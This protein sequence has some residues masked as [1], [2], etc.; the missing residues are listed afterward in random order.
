MVEVYW[1]ELSGR[2]T[3]VVQGGTV[4]EQHQSSH[5]FSLQLCPWISFIS[6]QAHFVHYMFRTAIRMAEVA[7]KRLKTSPVTIGTHNGH[8]HADEALAVYLL[9]LLPSYRDAD[10]VRTRDPSLLASCHTVVDVGGE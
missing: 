1:I 7:A 3:E 9:R 2:S 6:F 5:P 8:F 4:H 10:L